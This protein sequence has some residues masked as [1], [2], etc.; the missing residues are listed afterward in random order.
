[1]INFQTLKKNSTN[2]ESLANKIAKINK[3]QEE[4][5]KTDAR[6]WYP[7]TDKAGNG[8][9]IIRFLP[10]PAIDGEDSLP[11]VK[12]FSH[13]FQSPTGKWYIENSLTTFEKKDPVGELNRRLWNSKVDEY[14]AIARK[15][16]RKLSYISNILVIADSKNPQN[17]GKVFLYRY[18]QKI[19]DKI[20]ESMFPPLP[21]EPKIVPFDFWSGANFKL[22]IRQVAGYRNYDLSKFDAPSK[23]VESDDEL[24]KIWKSEYSLLEFLSPEKF[25]SYDELK[26]ILDEAIGCDSSSDAAFDAVTAKVITKPVNTAK[27]NRITTATDD[28][29]TDPPPSSWDNNTSET[30][31]DATYFQN[32]AK[33]G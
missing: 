29:E 15:Q 11:V 2:L 30:D 3:G 22:S 19:F 7:E 28:E 1:M 26:V 6:F 32:L 23:L 8:Y 17:E 13:G 31:E 12:Y 16:K 24:E 14:V 10:G 9:A 4:Y 25:K 5:N 20:T 33:K 18:G 27:A 21:D